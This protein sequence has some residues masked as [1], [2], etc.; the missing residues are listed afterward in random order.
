MNMKATGEGKTRCL[1]VT[2]CRRPNTRC[3]EKKG[4]NT[5]SLEISSVY[6]LAS[7][8]VLLL[9]DYFTNQVKNIKHKRKWVMP[10]SRHREYLTQCDIFVSYVDCVAQHNVLYVIHKLTLKS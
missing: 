10:S 5:G 1:S 7:N 3:G 8:E 2:M 4:V 6:F 9:G